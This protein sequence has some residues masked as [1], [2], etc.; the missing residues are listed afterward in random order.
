MIGSSASTR[1]APCPRLLPRSAISAISV[2]R[3]VVP[4]AV[5]KRQH[6]R[7]PRHAAAHPARQATQAP[8]ALGEHA[9]DEGADRPLPVFVEERARQRL[10]HRIGDEQRHQHAAADDR[11]RH[12]QVALE[13]A[14]P[15]DA[16]GRQ[17]HERRERHEAARADAELV[18]REFAELRVERREAPAARAD[19]EAGDRQADGADRAARQQPAPLRPARRQPCADRAHRE[20]RQADEEPAAPLRRGLHQAVGALRLAEDLRNGFVPGRI[21]DRVPGQQQVRRKAQCDPR[22]DPALRAPG[23]GHGRRVDR[24]AAGGSAGIASLSAAAS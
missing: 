3:K 15:R 6:Q 5:S 18:D 12:E 4:A 8:D 13:E 19:G 24:R 17:Q 7:V 2:P 16:E 14:E 11:G 1:S 10:A 21:L 9:R 23:R 20:P 22:P